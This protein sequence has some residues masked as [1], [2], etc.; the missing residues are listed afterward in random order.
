MPSEQPHHPSLPDLRPS[1]SQV[2]ALL[3]GVTRERA[4]L[5]ALLDAFEAHGL[6]WGTPGGSPIDC[7]GRYHRSDMINALNSFSPTLREEVIAI[8]DKVGAVA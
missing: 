4:T 7:D 3:R 8:F 1:R 6:L 2:E 5:H